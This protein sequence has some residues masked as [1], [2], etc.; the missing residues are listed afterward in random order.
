MHSRLAM[1]L[2]RYRGAQQQL[3]QQQ[4]LPSPRLS[5]AWKRVS[6]PECDAYALSS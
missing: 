3:V 2:M 6:A 4:A 5:A 1:R